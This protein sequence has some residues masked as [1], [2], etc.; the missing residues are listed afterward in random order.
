M[1]GWAV[2]PGTAGMGTSPALQVSRRTA[3]TA[4]A[5]VVTTGAPS[6]SAWRMV[7]VQCW[8]DRFPRARR[9]LH[10]KRPAVSAPRN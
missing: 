8:V 1:A 4:V 3:V 10:G 7:K 9:G 6:A 2:G 5:V